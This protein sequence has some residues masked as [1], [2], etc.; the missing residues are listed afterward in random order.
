MIAKLL[1]ILFKKH[2]LALQE[3]AIDQYIEEDD[4]LLLNMARNGISYYIRGD[5]DKDGKHTLYKFEPKN[6]GKT[7]TMILKPNNKSVKAI[8]EGREKV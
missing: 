7:Q 4:K 8:R 2:I 5:T 6:M 1:T 3:S